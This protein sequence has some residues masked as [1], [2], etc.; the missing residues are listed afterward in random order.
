MYPLNT[1][2]AQPL[3]SL[4]PDYRVEPLLATRWAYRGGNTWRFVLRQGVRF[5]DGQPLTAAAVRS[6]LEQVV[7]AGLGS[8]TNLGENSMR[9]VDDSTID[10]TPRAPNLRLPEQLVHPNFSIFALGTDPAVRP[11][12][13]GPFRFV[14]YV[15]H[16]RIIVERNPEY[17][18]MPARLERITF[19][20]YPD[21]TT[22]VLA[23][24]A[25]SVDLIMDLSREQV[26]AVSR[27]RD[28]AVARAPPGFVLSFQVNAHGRPPHDLLSDRTIRRAIAVAIDREQIVQRL[29]QGEAVAVQNMTVP[30]VLGSF[31]GMVQG[32]SYA[33]DTARRLLDAAGWRIGPDGLR[34]RAGRTLRLVLLANPEAEA[35]TVEFLQAQLRDV[36]IGVQWVRLADIGSY[37]ARLNRGEFD[38]NVS[39]SN[40]NDANPLFLPSLIHYSKSERPFSRWQR[41][42]AEFDHLVEGG[43]RT[44]DPAEARRLAAAAIHLAVDVEAIAIPIAALIRLYGVRRAVRGFV[45]HPS[46]TNQSWAEV[47]LP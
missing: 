1:N 24:S 34:A 36:G 40:Q 41:V 46:Q 7:R 8:T 16:Q 33:P 39:A 18:G 13:T 10:L 27:N 12:G 15:P 20:F 37:A 43:I 35:A 5:H 22:R 29:W 38:L 44:P 45:P 31:A 28:L 4:T 30:A 2:V 17:W 32:F 23:L 9:V 19:R 26:P 21:A 11:I 3:V 47:T 6:S 42:G 14:E 25:G